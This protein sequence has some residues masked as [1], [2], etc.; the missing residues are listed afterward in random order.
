MQ[1]TSQ[2]TGFVALFMETGRNLRLRTLDGKRS[3]ILRFFRSADFKNLR[4]QR[5]VGLTIAKQGQKD[6]Q[7]I[8]KEIA[9]RYR[10]D[11][12][13]TLFFHWRFNP[14]S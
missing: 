8:A 1:K 6:M 9:F 5:Q 12:F 10:I 4:R 2:A 3:G 14:G 7:S 13:S 11:I